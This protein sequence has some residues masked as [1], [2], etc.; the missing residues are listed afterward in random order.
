MADW[1]I[2][3]DDDTA[4]LK[5]AGHILSRHGMRVTA[6]KSGEILLEYVKDHGMPDVVLLDILM[7]EMDG[8]ETLT[9]IRE[10]EKEKGY[11]ETPVVFLT[12]DED[13]SIEKR[14]FEMG[15]SDFV[16]KPFDPE[17]LAQ[18]IMHVINDN[19][20]IATIAEEAA[21]DPLTG[22][23]N[24]TAT[25]ERITPMCVN[26][27][28]ALCM[29][30]L[31]SFKLVND[32][33]GHDMGDRVLVLFS[34]I[35]MKHIG[36]ESVCGRIGGDEFLVF[37]VG[38]RREGDIKAFAEAINADLVSGAMELLGK[39][40]RI[41]L[42]AS[43]GAVSVPQYGTDYDELFSM[44]DK[45]VYTV[46]DRGK[47]GYA[48]YRSETV[49]PL[50]EAMNGGMDLKT[51][52][53]LLEERSI[54]QSVMWMGREAF[55]N[56]YRYM[57]RYL[58][59]YD[60]SAYK[61][62]FTLRFKEGLDEE[63]RERSVDSLRELIK[64]SLRNSDIMVQIGVE[65]FFLLLPELNPEHVDRVIGRMVTAWEKNE[66]S[67][68]A[69]LGYEYSGALSEEDKPVAE[70]VDHIVVVDD[71]ATNL[72]MA[73]HIL[74][75]EGMKVT[76]LNT[77]EDLIEFIKYNDPSLILL[78]INMPGMDGF[79]TMQKITAK[80][81][82]MSRIPVIFLTA[83]DDDR[84]EAQGFRLG[85][86]DFIRKPFVPEILVVRVRHAIELIRLQNRLKTEVNEKVEEN[87][88]LTMHIIQALAA[89]IDAKDKYTSGHSGRVA[90]YSKEIAA[91]CGYDIDTQNRIYMMGLLHDV[92]KIGVRDYVIT[93]NGKL[94]KEEY[95]EIKD[96]T[97]KGDKILNKIVE[98][99]GLSIGARWHHERYDGS[100]YPDGLKMDDIPEAS[101]I[102]AVADAYDAMTS[103]RSYRGA[104]PQVKVREEIVN[105]R[106]SQFDP[107]FADIMLA[108]IDE[109]VDYR[110][111]EEDGTE[112][113]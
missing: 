92:G 72:K 39:D 68:T 12:A 1:V 29:I 77:G 99:P 6:L 102:I 105:G 31:D 113:E 108:M 23:L 88:Q 67:K 107:V 87:E 98:M 80:G 17:V 30:D 60:V 95:E 47:H 63:I 10:Y 106:G 65:Q 21:R 2:V 59:R 81:G 8:F 93:K 43:V 66:Y 49:N 61:V 14:G 96:H 86:M 90:S 48:M 20:K 3:V 62:L 38:M 42:G 40:M 91:R 44:A 82:R 97:V 27:S 100:G 55:S 37:G 110:L 54:P 9:R 89:A 41:P 11:S 53:K 79:E 84:T 34:E 4:N 74:T 85:A 45:A 15:V 18:R 26:E 33:Y 19:R 112:E 13:R 46:K 32:I 16:R 51:V 56:V 83:D 78:D 35:L 101:R 22:F 52:S 75:K 36:E 111:R 103:N 94:S 70:D 73:E 57:M 64:V 5:M 25:R 28:G 109:D 104:L 24:K 69:D 71:A 58:E 7:P 50:A 76:C